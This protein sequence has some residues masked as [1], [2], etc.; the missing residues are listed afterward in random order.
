L[1]S[2]WD[3]IATIV[4][5]FPRSRFLTDDMLTLYTRRATPM[6]KTVADRVAPTPAVNIDIGARLREMWS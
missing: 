4:A 6:P 1:V 3:S 2:I 5:C